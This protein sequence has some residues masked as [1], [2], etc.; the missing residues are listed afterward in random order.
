MNTFVGSRKL[1]LMYFLYIFQGATA[2]GLNPTYAK[3]L[4]VCIPGCET[5]DQTRITDHP[6]RTNTTDNLIR[7][8][9]NELQYRSMAYCYEDIE[10]TTV[11][12]EE[13]NLFC[14]AYNV[15]VL[16]DSEDRSRVTTYNGGHLVACGSSDRKIRLLDLATGRTDKNISGHAG[17]VKCLYISEKRGF[18]LSGSYDT[19]IRYC[20]FERLT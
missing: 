12:L 15:F 10:T 16:Q 19:S 17:S 18:V 6:S 7:K 13:R 2:K 4:E 1:N 5:E 8:R 20:N 9:D 11:E 14:G 3:K